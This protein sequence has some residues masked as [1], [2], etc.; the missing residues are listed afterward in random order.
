MEGLV[1]RPQKSV[2][3]KSFDSIELQYGN[4]DGPYRNAP[5]IQVLF[6]LCSSSPVPAE[7]VNPD[8][9]SYLDRDW[10]FTSHYFHG[11]CKSFA[12]T[13]KPFTSRSRIR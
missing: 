10:T 5:G 8:I 6:F 12:L 9:L 1:F 3:N 4:R 2:D 11:N 13:A 7:N